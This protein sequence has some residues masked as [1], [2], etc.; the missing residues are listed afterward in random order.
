MPSSCASARRGH[1]LDPA[2]AAGGPAERT[3]MTAIQTWRLAGESGD[4]RA[5][6]TALAE[7]VELVSPITERYA[8]RGHREV[9]TGPESVFAVVRRFR[10]VSELP[11]AN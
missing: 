2:S 9:G 8:F 11:D 1:R 3:P 6:L 7:D 5:A 10:S 4:H